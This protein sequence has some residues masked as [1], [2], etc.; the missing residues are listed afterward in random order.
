MSPVT[1]RNLEGRV[2]IVTGGAKGIGQAI[3]K[4]LV[5][6][7]ALVEVWDLE[8]SA[9]FPHTRLDVTDE[10]SIAKAVADLLARRQRLDILVN[11]AGLVGATGPVETFPAAAWRKIIDIN[12]TGT[13]LC[14]K[15]V[16]PAM[17]AAG[18]GRIVNIASIAGKDG[19]PEFAA[20][21]ASKGGVLALTKS[22]GKELAKTGILVN[23]VA[24][25]AIE[26]DI[27][28][29]MTQDQLAIMIQ[30]SPM[31]RLGR[32]EEC[33]ALTAWLVSDECTF[34]TGAV[35]DLSGGRAVY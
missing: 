30:K 17:R 16:T 3:A 31:G 5:A 12:L 20:Y 6:A 2:A 4:R 11:N 35:F 1:E 18:R 29:Q 23:A 8:P 22:M 7:G 9:E 32:V 34:S 14:S 13:F 26:T 27:L 21:S 15:A 10:P 28:Q 33:A 25:A 24:P 19:T